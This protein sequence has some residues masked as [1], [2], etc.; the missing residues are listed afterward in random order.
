MKSLETLLHPF[1]GA[2]EPC[3]FPAAHDRALDEDRVL[4]HGGDQCRVSKLRIVEAERLVRRATAA[5]KI[6]GADPHLLERSLDL[7]SAGW[8]LHIIDDPRLDG[9]A[10]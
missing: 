5:Q 1:R 3:A 4:R 2:A 6:A 8:R 10:A 7:S 9:F